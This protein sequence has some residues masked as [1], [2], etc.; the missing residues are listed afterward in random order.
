[1][2]ESRSQLSRIEILK[3]SRQLFSSPCTAKETAHIS[4]LAP[5]VYIPSE[6]REVHDHDHLGERDF[7]LSRRDAIDIVDDMAAADQSVDSLTE[8]QPAQ[9]SLTC[10]LD[11][12]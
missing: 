9:L 3:N 10:T 8:G 7:Y 1:V 4:L 6:R 11:G 2:E 5:I 12:P